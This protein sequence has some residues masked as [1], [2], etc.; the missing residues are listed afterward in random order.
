MLDTR[1]LYQQIILDHNRRPRNFRAIEDASRHADGNN[2]LCGDTVAIDLVFEGETIA[3][4][5]FQGAGCAISTASASVMTDTVKGKTRDE[6]MHLIEQFRHL[7]TGTS[8]MTNAGD[9][10]VF[11]GV[12]D[13]PTR[14][15]CA[16]LAWHTLKAALQGNDATI[17]TE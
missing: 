14:V 5:A 6:A 10:A 3:D 7:V 11:A 15:K 4:V 1:E 17:T 2:P 9:L 16:T 12:R 13:Y 8:E